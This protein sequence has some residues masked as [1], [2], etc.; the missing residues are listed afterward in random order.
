MSRTRQNDAVFLLLLVSFCT[1]C[2]D[3]E[4]LFQEEDECFESIDGRLVPCNADQMEDGSG[5]T[6]IIVQVASPMGEISD[7]STHETLGSG[8]FII[9][10]L[11]RSPSLDVPDLTDTLLPLQ[12]E[13]IC[14]GGPV[15]A[16]SWSLSTGNTIQFSLLIPEETNCLDTD[17]EG[18]F[19][20]LV[21]PFDVDSS[22]GRVHF[23]LNIFQNE[24]QTFLST[25]GTVTVRGDHLVL[26][27]VRMNRYDPVGGSTGGFELRG[28]L[29]LNRSLLIQGG[30]G[31][32]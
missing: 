6:P 17:R 32:C 26:D 20:A 8:D 31:G 3:F 23:L 13:P 27:Q 29:P 2:S 1:C 11:E 28:Q 30:S 14:V 22:G 12:V 7:E 24:I 19:C 21:Y 15:R 25:Y 10:V 5:R 16:A 9:E 4:D 18:A